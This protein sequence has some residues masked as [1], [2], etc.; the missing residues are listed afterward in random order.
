MKIGRNDPCFCWS[1]KKYKK[2]CLEKREAGPLAVSPDTGSFTS[3]ERA[4]AIQKLLKFASGPEFIADRDIGERLF[5]GGRLEDRT[6]EEIRRV[7][8][9]PQTDVNFNTW[10][11]YD[12]DV[13]NEQTVAD[14]FLAREGG[15]LTAGEAAYLKAAAKTHFRLYEVERVESDQGFRLKDLWTG[16]SLQVAE[17]AATRSF[18]QWDLMATRLMNLGADGWVSDGGIYD[19][20]PRAKEPLLRA[21]RSE[22]K[23]FQ[24]NFPGRDDA[25]FFKRIGMFFNHW[26]LDWVVFP[27]FP[28]MVTPEGDEMVFTKAHFDI[29]DAD[30]LLISLEARPDLEKI[31]PEAY[32]WRE[33]IPDGQRSL[34]T[35]TIKEN[36]LIL[37]TVSKERAE[38]GR[39]LLEEIAGASVRYRLTEYQDPEQAIKASEGREIKTQN[40]IPEEI[41][42]PLLKKFLDDH[43]RKWLDEELPALSYR[44]PRHAV[45]LKTFRP[46]VIDLLKSMENMEARAATR[47]KTPYDFGWIW[48]ES[49]LE[50]ERGG[51]NKKK[52]V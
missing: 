8:E 2:C 46:K 12:M 15:R 31:E 11:L 21:L 27:P 10:F 45:K 40:P 52:K 4:S 18:V 38:R 37:E 33:A 20:P 50:G 28:K 34:G 17:R 9:L 13:D 5:W 22:H 39:R 42:A 6:D 32:G 23:R 19:Y 51:K 47:G 36:R 3:E 35:F 29:E 24:R 41:Q 25:A 14:F 49:G 26:W 30:R 16:E 1:G 7:E 43:Y 44:T 48:R